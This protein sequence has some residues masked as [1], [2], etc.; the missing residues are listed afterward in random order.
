MGQ[1]V[2][3][4]ELLERPVVVAEPVQPEP[5]LVMPTRTLLVVAGGSRRRGDRRTTNSATATRMAIATLSR[6]LLDRGRGP[7]RAA[8]VYAP[9][10]VL[11]APVDRLR[12]RRQARGV[13]SS[14]A[15]VLMLEKASSRTQA[16]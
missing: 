3:G 9:A 2:A 12:R 1:L 5:D 7:F 14:S 10:L 4:R 6:A 11:A 16:T 13:A 15:R 8:P